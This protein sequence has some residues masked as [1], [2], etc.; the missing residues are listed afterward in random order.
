MLWLEKMPFIGSNDK[1][2]PPFLAV[3]STINQ[4]GNNVLYIVPCFV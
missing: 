3:I 4:T 1:E 2:K